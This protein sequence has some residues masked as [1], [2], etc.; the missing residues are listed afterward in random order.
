MDTWIWCNLRLYKEGDSR[1]HHQHTKNSNLCYQQQAHRW[2]A[3]DPSRWHFPRTHRNILHRPNGD[4]SNATG[5]AGSTER[6]PCICEQRA[7]RQQPIP[8]LPVCWHT[9]NWINLESCQVGICK[10]PHIAPESWHWSHKPTTAQC[11]VH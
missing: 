1:H 6:L 3:W 4:M 2:C 9:R 10:R 8:G 5:R 7:P 11:E